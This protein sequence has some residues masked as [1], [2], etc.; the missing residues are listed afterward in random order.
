M[1]TIWIF[2]P[3]LEKTVADI[4]LKTQYEYKFVRVIAAYFV[5]LF[6]FIFS[7]P[8]ERISNIAV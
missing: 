7:Y 1:R 8:N 3:N 2:F 4:L 6:C 5:P